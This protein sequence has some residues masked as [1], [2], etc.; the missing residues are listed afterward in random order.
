METILTFAWFLKEFKI[1]STTNAVCLAPFPRGSNFLPPCSYAS[2]RQFVI[3]D[4]FTEF[5]FHSFLLCST[6]GSR[7][8]NPKFHKMFHFIWWNFFL[9]RRKVLNCSLMLKVTLFFS[10]T[11]LK[12]W[13]DLF[14]LEVLKNAPV[15]SPRHDDALGGWYICRQPRIIV[16]RDALYRQP[17]LKFSRAGNYR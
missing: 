10:S 12:Y 8:P 14:S 17:L 9:Q 15:T 7:I 11:I 13:R 2:I 3:S 5:P 6:D 1:K 16:F 4:F